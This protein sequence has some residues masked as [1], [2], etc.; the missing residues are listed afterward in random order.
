MF[1]SNLSHGTAYQQTNPAM[2]SER[3]APVKLAS[4]ALLEKERKS[5]I[6]TQI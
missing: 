4:S 1:R 5:A 3:E 2:K 6:G